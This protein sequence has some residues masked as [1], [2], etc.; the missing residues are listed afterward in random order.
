MQ[1]AGLY[2]DELAAATEAI[3]KGMT[4]NGW[5]TFTWLES[6]LFYVNTTNQF[7][8]QLEFSIDLPAYGSR[9]PQ[10]ALELSDLLEM[11]M[12]S[13]GYYELVLLT[14]EQRY[15]SHSM[16]GIGLVLFR[17][18]YKFFW[19]LQGDPYDFGRHDKVKAILAEEGLTY[20]AD[21][22]VSSAWDYKN[23]YGTFRWWDV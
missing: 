14:R 7:G 11:R 18:P 8:A 15:S 6:E 2:D 22:E 5:I 20:W 12:T 4:G 9:Q 17:L 10:R 21:A 3:A 19:A 1:A 13:E 16:R 23:E